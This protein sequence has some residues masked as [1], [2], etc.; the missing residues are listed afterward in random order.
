MFRVHETWFLPW[1][2]G[3]KVEPGSSLY[4]STELANPFPVWLLHVKAK[5]S[6]NTAPINRRLIFGLLA[7]ALSAAQ[8]D[9]WDYRRLYVLLPEQV[10][11]G[12]HLVFARCAAITECAEPEAIESCWRI[13]TDSGSFLWSLHRTTFGNERSIKIV[14]LAD[15]DE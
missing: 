6:G 14:W 5:R 4:R 12:D 13:E 10:A 9:C 11:G 1:P 8:L 7:E 3:L 2:E 15:D